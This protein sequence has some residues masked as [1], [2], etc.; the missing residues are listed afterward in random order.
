M[1]Q[2]YTPPIQN[3]FNKQQQNNKKSLKQQIGGSR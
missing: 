2:Q 1:G 3:N